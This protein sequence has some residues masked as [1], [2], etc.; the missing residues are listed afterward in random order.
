V[1][2]F[3]RLAVLEQFRQ[4]LLLRRFQLAR[5]A[6]QQLARRLQEAR[7]QLGLVLQ[8]FQLFFPGALDDLAYLAI[9]S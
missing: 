4:L 5:L 3:Q 9:T 6:L 2:G 1:H 7:F 8:V